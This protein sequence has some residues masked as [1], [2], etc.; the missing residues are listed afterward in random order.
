MIEPDTWDEDSMPWEDPVLAELVVLA[1]RHVNRVN[2]QRAHGKPRRKVGRSAPAGEMRT[3]ARR[4][5]GGR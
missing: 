5:R 1:M 3:P 4:E 2:R